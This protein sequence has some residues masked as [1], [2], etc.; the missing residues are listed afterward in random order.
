MASSY[1]VILHWTDVI[2]T[3]VAVL[4]IGLIMAFIP[5]YTGIG[6]KTA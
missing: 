6:E 5:V 4:L 2:L 1:P 3:S